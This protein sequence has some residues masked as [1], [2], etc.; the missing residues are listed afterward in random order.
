MKK[1][2]KT[3]ESVKYIK[4]PDWIYYGTDR[5]A[6]RYKNPDGVL[7]ESE[8]LPMDY[9]EVETE[10]AKTMSEKSVYERL[11]FDRIY[12]GLKE[13]I[14]RLREDFPYRGKVFVRVKKGDINYAVRVNEVFDTKEG[15]IVYGEI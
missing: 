3:E 1:T 6:L 12:H 9:E 11:S 8:F 13:E 2:K 14:K 4:I 10:Q 15:L 7:M 5:V